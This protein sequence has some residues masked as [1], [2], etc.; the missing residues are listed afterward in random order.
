[1]QSTNDWTQ[2]G[3]FLDTLNN[4][5]SD[6]ENVLDVDRTLWMMAFSNL[7]I[8]LDG[9][10]NTIPHNFYMFKD[11]NGRFSPIIW[12]LNGSFGT[13]KNGLTQPVTTQDLQELDVFHEDSNNQ[14]KMT[15]KMFSSD[16]YKRV[17]IAH[18][19]TILNE[20]FANKLNIN[21]KIK[22]FIVLIIC[23]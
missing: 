7:T 23:N 13:F 20:Q 1:M 2:L 21:N 18:M 16:Q 17:Y 10:I 12:D 5:F 6:I 19:R 15:T 9:P 8:T 4:Y 14:N 22:H 11:N 3:N